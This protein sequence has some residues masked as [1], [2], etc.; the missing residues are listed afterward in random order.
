MAETVYRALTARAPKRRYPVGPKS[1]LLAFL[2][3]WLPTGVLDIVRTRL[4]QVYQPFGS[5]TKE[6]LPAPCS[7]I[8]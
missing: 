6:C 2:G 5:A 3:V 4:F 7:P 8:D 1:R